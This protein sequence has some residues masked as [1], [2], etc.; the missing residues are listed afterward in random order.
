MFNK[1]QKK[2]YNAFNLFKKNKTINESNINEAIKQIR[3]A[4]IEA[5]V[6]FK[7]AKKITNEIKKKY[8]GQ[9]VISNISPY[10]LIIKIVHDELILLM[11]KKGVEID[12]SKKPCIILIAGLQG[13]GKTTFSAKLAKYLK[14]KKKKNP[15]LIA[16]DTYRPAAIKQLELLG[17][18]INVPVFSLLNEKKPL[19]IILKGINKSKK[20]NKDV[21]IID[22][23][24][25]LSVDEF[26][27]NEIKEIVNSIHPNE[28]LFVVDSM[29]GQDSINTTKIFYKNIKFNGIVLTK[30]DGDSKGGVVLTIK[31]LI[32]K[33]VKFIS[34]GENLNAIDFFH[35][36]RMVKRILGMGDIVSLVEKAQ[37]QFNDKTTKKLYKKIVKNK[38]DLNDLLKQIKKIKK[39]GNIKELISMIPGANKILNKINIDNKT[40]KKTESII[41][42]M[43]LKERKNY[44]IINNIDRKKRIAKGAG[45]NIKDV[46]I[47][48]K[49][50]YKMNKMM[51][52]INN[53]EM[54]K[55]I[56]NIIMNKNNM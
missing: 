47:I 6:N 29:M 55:M 17:E 41:Y 53:N 56:K 5:D 7:I 50:F 3:K 40:L 37:E 51:K 31:S 13:S 34:N 10:Q 46:E 42:S 35:P 9:K 14:Y 2:L 11:G 49:Q 8:I 45:V 16:A 48:L 43:S 52:N 28:T 24:G 27:M 12:L 22:T 30:M 4:F 1:L 18:K 36:E 15:I 26:M 33:P 20:N 21:I 25:R 19:K 23:A 39:M 38:F 54:Q 44:K 32:N